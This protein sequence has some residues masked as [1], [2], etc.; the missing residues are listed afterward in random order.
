MAP[1]V[2]NNSGNVSL[3]IEARFAKERDELLADLPLI[4]PERRR[5]EFGAAH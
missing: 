4:A 2:Q 5:K 1:A 3:R